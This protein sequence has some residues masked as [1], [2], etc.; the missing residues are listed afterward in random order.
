MSLMVKCLTNKNNLT[1]EITKNI[2]CRQTITNKWPSSVYS[3][4]KEKVPN[5]TFLLMLKLL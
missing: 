4:K 2:N 1:I 3:T 5:A